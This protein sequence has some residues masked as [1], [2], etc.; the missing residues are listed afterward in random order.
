MEE[1]FI[2][3]VYSECDRPI[4]QELIVYGKVKGMEKKTKVAALTVVVVI[5]VVAGLYLSLPSVYAEVTPTGNGQYTINLQSRR[6][7]W[8]GLRFLRNGTPETLIGEVATIGASIIV[9]DIDGNQVNVILPPRW[10]VDGQ[11]IGIRDLFDGEPLSVGQSVS[12]QTLKLELVRE[13]ITVKAYI[14]YEIQANGETIKA[15]LP[16]NI[17][18]S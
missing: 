13:R 11:V 5:A 10:L 7:A 8:L 15:L 3:G 6:R 12:L 16:V 18:T 17:E 4:F 2:C 1:Y 14:A 9:M